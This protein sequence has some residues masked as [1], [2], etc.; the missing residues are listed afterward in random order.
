MTKDDMESTSCPKLTC[1]VASAD[2][3]QCIRQIL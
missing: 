2:H 1:T 3:W